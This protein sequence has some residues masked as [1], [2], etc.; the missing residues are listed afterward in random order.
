VGSLANNVDEL[1]KASEVWP[2]AKILQHI[3]EQKN[4]T[5]HITEGDLG[6]LTKFCNLDVP[7]STPDQKCSNGHNQDDEETDGE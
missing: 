7:P 1:I 3:N 5:Q 6:F 2:Q 4:H